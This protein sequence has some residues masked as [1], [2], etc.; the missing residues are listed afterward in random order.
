MSLISAT[1]LRVGM[2]IRHKG[3]LCR[4]TKVDHVTPGNWRGMVHTKMVNIMKGTQVENRFRAEDKVDAVRLEQKEMEYLYRDSDAYVFMDTE[5]YDQLHFSPDL[6]G[7][8]VNLLVA[9]IKCQVY[10]FESTPISIE[11]PLTVDL[12]VVETEPRLKGATVSAS[13]KPATVET[14]ATILVPQFIEPGETIRIDTGTGKY[15]ERAK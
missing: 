4:I 7:E 3:D 8:S 15:I 12:K 6:L 2:A 13:M 9:N 11:L 1:D 5:T 10:F 14:G